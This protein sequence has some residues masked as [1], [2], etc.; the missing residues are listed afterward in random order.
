MREGH[1]VGVGLSWMEEA[2]LRARE[3]WGQG[4]TGDKQA[5]VWWGGQ[6]GAGGPSLPSDTIP[7]PRWEQPGQVALSGELC[8][9]LS[10]P[11]WRLRW[12]QAQGTL[13]QLCR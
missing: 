8:Q 3:E 6:C 5:M 11:Q 2:E 9:G 10:L 7:F 1:D 12:V 4:E 13:Q